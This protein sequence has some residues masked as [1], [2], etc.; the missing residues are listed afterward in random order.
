E[1]EPS[2]LGS[3]EFI[4]DHAGWSI[5]SVT[6]GESALLAIAADAPRAVVL[7]IMLP[8][9]NGFEVLKEVRGNP[10][11]AQ[12]P[13]LVLTA[14]GQQQDRRTATE[15]GAS[16]FISKPYANAEVVDTMRSLIG[17][18]EKIS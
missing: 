11:T 6:D 4:L 14:K 8:R 15:L 18:P 7:D 12:L 5:K 13:I 10:S 3:L 17:T 2:I 1:D 16:A 9:R